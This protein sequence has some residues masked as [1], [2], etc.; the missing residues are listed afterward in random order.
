MGTPEFAANNLKVLVESGYNIVGVVTVPDKPSGRGLK[1]N[2]SP[3]KEY[4]LTLG[5]PILQPISLKEES[6][7]EA[8][9]LLKGDLFVVVAFRMLPKIIWSMPPKGTFN[10]HASLL[11]QYRGAAPINWA[12]IN[13][14]KITGVTTFLLDEKIDTGK[15]LLHKECPIHSNQSAGELHDKLMEIGAELVKETIDLIDSNNYQ[16]I[17]QPSFDILKPAPKLTRDTG[18][19]DWK[20]EALTIHNLIRGLSPYPAAHSVIKSQDKEM[21]IKIYKSIVI[22]NSTPHDHFGKVYSDGKKTLSVECGK[23][24]IQILELQVAGKKRLRINEFLAGWHG[25]WEDVKFCR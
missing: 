5:V 23:G 10:L 22:D 17:D 20:E 18:E 9:S 15:I 8:L 24:S 12:V 6:F 7:I 2:I 16:A 4:A 19:I 3:V 21:E 13:G 1:I 11:P 14:E 25:S